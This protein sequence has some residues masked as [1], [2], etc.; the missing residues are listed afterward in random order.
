[1]DVLKLN[2]D[3]EIPAL[4]L[5]LCFE[6]AVVAGREA[7]PVLEL[8]ER[9]L[10]DVAVLVVTGVEADRPATT[11][12][13]LL[14]VGDLVRRLRDYCLDATAA[15]VGAVSARRVGLVPAQRLGPGSWP[16]LARPRDAQLAS[17]R[18]RA[19][20]SLA[21]PGVNAITSGSPLP[22]TRAW[23]LVV[24]PPRERPIA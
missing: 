6:P 12:A 1:M 21:W 2:N 11:R 14:T 15:Q 22:S 24:R 8:V 17:S 3:I 5:E 4:G 13:L 20:E 7:P 19:G 10:D 16:T 9:S 18:G 23:V